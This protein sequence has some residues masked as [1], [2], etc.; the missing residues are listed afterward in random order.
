MI[1]YYL[2]YG[3]LLYIYI[4]EKMRN[5]NNRKKTLS[6]AFFVTFTIILGCRHPSMGYDLGY[7]TSYGYLQ[8]FKQLSWLSW[9]EA[10]NLKSF[11]NYERGYIVYNK[12]LGSLSDDVQI[13]LF[14]TALIS[15]ALISIT[16]YK[17]S[18]NR[19]ILMAII[20]YTALPCFLIQ[21]SGLRQAIAIA[22]CTRAMQYI[23]SRRIT[24]FI[25]LILL[26]S[27]FHVTAL[28]FLP[29]YFI[30]IIPVK[31]KYRFVTFMILALVFLLKDSLF[32]VL[33]RL[34]GRSTMPDYNGAITLFF[35]FTLIYIFCSVLETK[36]ERTNGYM[37]LFYLACICQA[38]SSVYSSAIRMGYYYM[39]SIPILLP[40]A[41]DNIPKYSQRE[42]IRIL[43]YICFLGFGLY[44]LSLENSWAMSNPYYFFWQSIYG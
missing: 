23:E 43:V 15:F 36:D 4:E 17:L 21:F 8:S 27:L 25:L 31:S 2:V 44:T 37:N 41:I 26:A 24:P 13:L 6:I 42:L 20:I 32:Q 9:E 38:F 7:G 10:L 28:C 18:N 3:V 35:V 34:M 22:I 5:G 19:N 16:L 33:V 39:F 40:L 12:I 30:Y 29:A 1:V 14:A 11:L